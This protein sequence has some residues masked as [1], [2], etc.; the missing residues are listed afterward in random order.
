MINTIGQ[1]EVLSGA[2]YTDVPKFIDWIQNTAREFNLNITLE[3]KND[4]T[5]SNIDLRFEMT[6][7]SNGVVDTTFNDFKMLV[8]QPR[9]FIIFIVFMVITAAITMIITKMILKL[10]ECQCCHN[11]NCNERLL[12]SCATRITI[13][14]LS[15]LNENEE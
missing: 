4:K 6:E 2:L 9:L 15:L 13:C 5:P 11:N 8:T 7:K 1:C 3:E 12:T 10:R 14:D